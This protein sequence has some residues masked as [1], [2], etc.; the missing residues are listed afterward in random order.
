M[1]ELEMYVLVCKVSV[2]NLV[3]KLEKRTNMA[4]VTSRDNA[5]LLT[6]E[7]TQPGRGKL[8]WKQLSTP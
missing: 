2:F 1:A 7:T 6:S 4:A 3:F 5:L 8:R